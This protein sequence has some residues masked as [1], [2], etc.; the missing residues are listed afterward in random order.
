MFTRTI[1]VLPGVVTSIADHGFMINIGFSHRK[2]FLAK[3]KHLNIGKSSLKRRGNAH[4]VACLEQLKVGFHGLFQIKE[5]SSTGSSRIV[6]LKMIDSNIKRLVRTQIVR[7]SANKT[8]RLVSLVII[9]V[10]ITFS[11]A[12]TGS[13]VQSDGEKSNDRRRTLCASPRV[14]AFLAQVRVN[15]LEVSFGEVKGFI[16]LQDLDSL[17][18]PLDQF[19]AEQEVSRCSTFEVHRSYLPST[20]SARSNHSLH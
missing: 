10:E 13:Q 16:H 14:T 4:R 9:A 18:T 11:Y 6:Q 2:G 19:A 3:G 1:Q 12:A 7:L 15:G 17:K 5:S 20:I 8:S